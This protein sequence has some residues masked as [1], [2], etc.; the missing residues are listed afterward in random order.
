MGGFG[1][2]RRGH[3]SKKMTSSV[4]QL[5]INFFQKNGAL[6]EGRHGIIE[7]EVSDE[8]ND[9]YFYMSETEI[10]FVYSS[11]IGN[12]PPK[13]YRYAVGVEWT[14]CNYGGARPWFT[15]PGCNRRC[16]IL[17][18]ANQNIFQCRKC[19]NLRYKSQMEGEFARAINRVYRHR[20]KLGFKGTLLDRASLVR[21]KNMHQSTFVNLVMGLVLENQRLELIMRSNR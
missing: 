1:S 17:Y 3:L 2:G 6:S 14:D 9:L 21:P 18:I 5:N 20:S 16:G 15:C 4:P 19:Q 11:S 10:T 12:Q 8:S 13:H 7:I